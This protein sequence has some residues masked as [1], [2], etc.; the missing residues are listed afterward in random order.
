MATVLVVDDEPVVRTL[1]TQVLQ[2]EGFS[3]FTAACA[4]QALAV[5]ATHRREID[6]LISDIVMPG[7]DGPALAARLQKEC[8]GLP[9]LL[10]SGH[11][12][13][14]QLEHGFEFLP[15]PFSMSELLRRVHNLASARRAA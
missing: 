5:F 4:A 14:G 9:V 12:D 6:L 13:A 3:V 11:C 15:K 1:M 7:M 10:M 2:Q 8:P